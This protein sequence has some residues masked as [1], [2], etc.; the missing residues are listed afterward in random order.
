MQNILVV[1]PCGAGKSTLAT[2]LAEL[3]QLELIHLDAHYWQ[4]GWVE[5]PK[6]EWH[7]TVDQ[8][9]Q[10]NGWVMDGN[11]KGTL[12]KRLQVADTVIFLDFPRW[13]CLWG[14]M[15]RLVRYVGRTR[16]DMAPDC[17]ERFNWAFMQYVW[18][19]QM[20][21]RPIVVDLLDQASDTVQ[22][23]IMRSPKEVTAFLETLQS[24]GHLHLA[25]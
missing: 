15:N 24:L 3:L 25:G 12:A 20:Q 23:I 19:F 9:L 2:Q 4:P 22:V 1:G 21:Y 6:V 7:R 18:N 5:S 17:P 10:K 16:P 11:Y 13:R 14:V 8:L